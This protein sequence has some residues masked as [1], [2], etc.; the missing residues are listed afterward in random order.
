MEKAAR[1]VDLFSLRAFEASP[2][3]PAIGRTLRAQI[4]DNVKGAS[5][6]HAD[7]LCQPR[8][9]VQT[10]QDVAMRKGKIILDERFRDA[11]F[12]IAIERVRFFEEPPFVGK[13]ARRKHQRPGER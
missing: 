6:N 2:A 7:D 3:P 8:I 11:A 12:A 5:A 10:A 9:A 1:D 13:D 4:D